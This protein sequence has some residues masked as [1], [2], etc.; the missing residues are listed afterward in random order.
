MLTI[1]KIKLS[2]PFKPMAAKKKRRGRYRDFDPLSRMR[3]VW[4]THNDKNKNPELPCQDVRATHWP[5]SLIAKQ[6]DEQEP[7]R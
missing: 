3:I 5:Q 1:L 4:E 2:N 6:Q 7:G